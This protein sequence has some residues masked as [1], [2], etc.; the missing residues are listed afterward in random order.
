[1]PL[2][3]TIQDNTASGDSVYDCADDTTGSGTRG[4]GNTWRGNHGATSS[5][6]GLCH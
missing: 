2:C 3:T 4:T 5:P 6:A 1:V